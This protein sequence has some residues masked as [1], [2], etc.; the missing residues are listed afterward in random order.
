MVIKPD[1]LLPSKTDHILWTG[2]IVFAKVWVITL[3]LQNNKNLKSGEK[4]TK[5]I[6]FGNKSGDMAA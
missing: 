4:A 1:I 6:L 5:G 2:I 3:N